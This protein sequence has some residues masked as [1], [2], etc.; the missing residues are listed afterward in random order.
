MEGSF[1]TGHRPQWTV[2]P[3]EE[4]EDFYKLLEKISNDMHLPDKPHLIS[5]VDKSD[6]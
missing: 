4:E 5:N 2:V 3:V 1:S 6:L